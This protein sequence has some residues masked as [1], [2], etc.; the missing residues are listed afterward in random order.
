MVPVC[1]PSHI[2]TNILVFHHDSP[3]DACSPQFNRK[4]NQSAPIRAFDRSVDPVTKALLESHKRREA[5]EFIA[6]TDP[7]DAVNNTTAYPDRNFE[8]S[9]EGIGYDAPTDADNPNGEYFGVVSEPWQEFSNQHQK[10]AQK[11]NPSYFD[12][13]DH[14]VADMETILR[15][16][17]RADPDTSM[18]ENTTVSFSEDVDEEP[19]TPRKHSQSVGRSKSIL[20]RL[21][22]L[23]GESEGDTSEHLLRDTRQRSRGSSKDLGRTQPQ[24]SAV[25]NEAPTTYTLAGVERVSSAK[26][27]SNY[28]PYDSTLISDYSTQGAHLTSTSPPP[29]PKKSTRG[30]SGH[31]SYPT[32]TADPYLDEHDAVFTQSRIPRALQ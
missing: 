6:P 19:V 2:L 20:G 5:G 21:R 3:Y 13:S 15:G 12:E 14:K 30:S 32:Q 9:D 1:I 27:P 18:K 17:R 16:G 28:T 22:R 26:A 8:A 10:S 31:I 25:P 11:S 29:V 23:R 4:N 7:Y 24:A